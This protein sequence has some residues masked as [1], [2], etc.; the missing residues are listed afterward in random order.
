M[1]NVPRGIIPSQSPAGLTV[2]APPTLFA[3]SDNEQK[4]WVLW[5]NP[6]QARPHFAKD[7]MWQGVSRED[8]GCSRTGVPGVHTQQGLRGKVPSAPPLR[9][10]DRPGFPERR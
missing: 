6:R 1:T 7:R 3:V 8:T 4:L 10:H 9:Q 2:S 5:A